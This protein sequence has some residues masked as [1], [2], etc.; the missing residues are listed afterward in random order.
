[1]TAAYQLTAGTGVVR[2]S[3]GATIPNDPRNADW[4][5]YAAWLAKGNAPDPAAAPPAPPYVPPSPRQWLERLAPATQANIAKAALADATGATLLWLLKAA[6]NP[7]I[8]VT[9]ADTNSGVSTMQSAG[10]ISAAE[11]TALLTP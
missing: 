1:M 5:A 11:A 2:A 9:N 4:Q 10:V 3:D 7:A 8:D 6:G